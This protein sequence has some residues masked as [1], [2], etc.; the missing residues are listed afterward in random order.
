MVSETVNRT[1]D[2]VPVPPE[3]MQRQNAQRGS[4]ANRNINPIYWKKSPQ[5][6]DPGWIFVGPSAVEGPDGR[7]VTRQAESMIRKGHVPLIE[8]S[9]TDK[10]DPSTG[11]PLT[12]DNGKDTGDRLNST[13]RWYWLF[14]NGGA[15]L[16]PI[17]QIVAYHWHIKPPY[18]LPKSVFP[19]L[20]EYDVPEP[21]WCPACPGDRPNRNSVEEVLQH[22][23]IEHRMTLPQARDL[24]QSTNGFKDAPVGRT[25]LAIRRKA[26][27][28]E[29]RAE[30]RMEAPPMPTLSEGNLIICDVCGEGP[31]KSARE[32]STHIKE[33]HTA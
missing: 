10:R 5:A 4:T 14:R 32:K 31:F 1:P 18:G 8:Y 24:E 13:D 26:K 16:F 20:D 2:L 9:Y 15:H 23:M 29:S 22:L 19:Q 25:G 21:F 3:W 27:T 30:Q 7:P 12:I 6:A 11:E 17:E 33:E 28:A